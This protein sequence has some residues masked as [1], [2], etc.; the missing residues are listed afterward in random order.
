MA[1]NFMA[2]PPIFSGENYQIWSVKMKSYLEASGLW[3]VVMSEIQPLQEDPTIAQ[4]RNYNDELIRRAKAKTCIH[5]AVSDVVFTRIMSCETIKEAWNTL[6]EAFQGNERTRQMQVLNLRREFE[7]LRMKEAETFKEYFDR[8][9]VVVNK[10]RLLR[11]DL[12]DRRI[13]EKV[14]A[15]LL[16]RFEAKISSLEDSRDLTMI[17][18]NRVDE[19][20]ANPRAEKIVEKRVVEGVFLARSQSSY[21]AKKKD[22]KNE[23]KSDEDDDDK[24]EK[25]SSCQHYK[26]TNH[27]HWKCWWRPDVVCSSCNQKGHMEKV[28]KRKQQEVQI[29]QETDDKKEELLF[30][31]T[32][33]ASDITNETWLIDSGCTHHMTHDKDMFVKLDRTH[34]SKV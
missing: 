19:L 22:W 6:Q 3:D 31:A 29:A 20:S 18:T 2:A 8:L 5:F 16:E 9:L 4:I 10:I 11:E 7:M 34:S 14:L 23:K 33:F 30:V 12:P 27:P 28:C 25:Y 32:C 1:K 13:V 15:S 21:K 26:K 17:F 24:K